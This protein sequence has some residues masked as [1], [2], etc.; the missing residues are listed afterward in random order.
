[1]KIKILPFAV[2]LLSVACVAG[3]VTYNA[4]QMAA[5]APSGSSPVGKKQAL[6]PGAM[7][8]EM[9]TG[10]IKVP[11]VI[12][13]E[14]QSDAYQSVVTGYGEA[15]AHYNVDYSAEV[16]GRVNFVS[17]QLESGIIVR[18][19]Q[20]LARIEDTQYQQ[21]LAQAQSDYA[22]AELD[23]L[24][25][26]RQ[27]EQARLEWQRS[28]I[29]GEPSSSLVLR[30][31]QLAAAKAVLAQA[32]ISV[33][34]A[35]R[36]LDKT[37]IKAPFDG[38]VI[39]R[40]VQP[41][42]YVQAGSSVVTL[43][44]IDRVNVEIPLSAAQ[45]ENLPKLANSELNGAQ[46]G[47]WQVTLTSADGDA[48][49]QGYVSRVEQHVDTDSRQRSLVVSVDQPLAQEVG[50]YPGTF[51][52]AQIEG[53]LMEDSW[54]LPASAISQQGELW[55]IDQDNT[56]RKV[57]AEKIFERSDSV[58]VMPID[59]LSAAKIVKRPLSSYVVGMRV[60]PELEG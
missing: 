14:V 50:L 11:S 53:A 49:W 12:V 52:R 1:M 27:G 18:K 55:F 38:L 60:Q 10:E 45:W 3:A 16:S 41:G 31:P 37:V 54:K 24:E 40:S 33:E 42:S 30:Q 56:L 44:S 2:T 23:L 15:Q 19:G 43:Y 34:K 7:P 4:S 39:E 51:V 8:G 58:Y 26:Q 20:V 35:Q 5:P 25:E 17:A 6:Q 13:V 57:A 32:K 59:S 36:D 22:Q 9:L 28:G 46:K 29:D 21:A 47:K 48:S